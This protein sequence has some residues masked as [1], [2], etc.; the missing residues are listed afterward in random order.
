M[1]PGMTDRSRLA[2]LDALRG[3][4]AMAVVLYH[5]TAWYAEEMG[6]HAPP[7][8]SLF[9]PFGHFGVELFFIISGFV[10]FLT[11]RQRRQTSASARRQGFQKKQMPRSCSTQ[12]IDSINVEQALS[13]SDSVVGFARS[14]FARLYPAFL[15][16][17]LVTLAV[18]ASGVS[19]WRVLAN[20]TMAPELIGAR[21]IDGSYWSLQYELVFYVL[22]AFCVLVMRWRAPEIPCAVWLA[23]A[24]AVRLSGW[25]LEF[26][27]LERLSLAWFA[28]LFVI[29]IMLFRLHAGEATR[30]SWVVLAVALEMAFLGPHWAFQPINPIV[31][32]L[33]I[34]GFATLVWFAVTP[35]G[36]MLAIPPL[37]FLGRVSYPLYLVH[38]APGFILIARLEAMG[39][40]P[41]LA[42]GVAITAAILLAWAI[43]DLV[44]APVGRWLRRPH[45]PDPAPALPPVRSGIS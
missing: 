26:R 29:G 20:L 24:L 13:R 8:S 15:T 1:I 43:T 27:T 22:A 12:P 19:A 5:Y 7:G 38:Q 41:D 44:E 35:R 33:M 17:I 4:A 23:V 3:I 25:D 11:L 9:V 10:I 18:D 31:Y 30:L 6:G 45:S 34:A 2:G 37:R 16:A 42:I 40:P 14:R 28:H 39:V 36:G 32:G 21:P